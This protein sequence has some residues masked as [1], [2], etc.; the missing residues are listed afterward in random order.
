MEEVLPFLIS[1]VVKSQR[2]GGDQ[3]I[4]SDTARPCSDLKILHYNVL[5]VDIRYN[6]AVYNDKTQNTVFCADSGTSRC[7]LFGVRS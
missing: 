5:T 6:D 2:G 3:L 1:F 4:L 7:T